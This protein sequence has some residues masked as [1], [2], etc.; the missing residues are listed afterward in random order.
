M[1]GPSLENEQ[2]LPGDWAHDRLNYQQDW[3]D[4]PHTENVL[5]NYVTKRPLLPVLIKNEFEKVNIKS[6]GEISV[7][8]YISLKT[9]VQVCHQGSSSRNGVILS[10]RLS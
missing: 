6:S 5:I 7:V 8:A 4:P 9:E 3:A 10:I 2:T 1:E